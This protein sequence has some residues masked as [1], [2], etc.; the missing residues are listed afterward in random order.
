MANRCSASFRIFPSL[1]RV[2]TA[3]EYVGMSGSE[4]RRRRLSRVSMIVENTSWSMSWSSTSGKYWPCSLR[5]RTYFCRIASV[6]LELANGFELSVGCGKFIVRH[7][8]S[9]YRRPVPPSRGFLR[10]SKRSLVGLLVGLRDA[11]SLTP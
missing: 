11:V 7:P 5:A 4:F 6:S 2:S 8:H 10:M 1:L 9:S 3:L